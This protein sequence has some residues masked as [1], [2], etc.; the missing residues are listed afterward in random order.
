VHALAG[1]HPVRVLLRG[2]SGRHG[3]ETNGE[4]DSDRALEA[5]LEDFFDRRS[6]LDRTLDLLAITHPHIDHVHGA[7][8]VR[9]SFKVE[10]VVTNGFL[11]NAKGNY[12]S[13]G[14]QQENLE[15]WARAHA[16]LETIQTTAVP[17]GG[18]TSAVIDPLRC[19]DE[20]PRI[21]VLW[22]HQKEQP[23]DWNEE[24]FDDANNHS[25][26]VRI[27]FGAASF[28]VT[29]DLELDAVPE[30]VSKHEGSEALDVD[31]WQV[32]HHGSAN[33]T[34]KAILDAVTPEIALLG[35]G[36]P[37]R[38]QSKFTAFA[39]GHPRAGVIS[40]LLDRLSRRRM[41]AEVPVASGVRN[42]KPLDLRE[43]IYATG[44]DGSVVVTA[45]NE[46]K[47]RVRTN[48]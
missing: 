43:A 24:T 16:E 38:D 31:V 13:G 45:D 47:Y 36:D 44:W 12:H 5:Y 39:H 10:H 27:D 37:E 32:S 41:A 18:T 33:G 25:V 2:H 34:G 1:D 28:L 30:V 19:A 22:G 20:D 9:S 21:R 15:E 4:F 46:G 48:Q 35:T 8:L 26:V 6:D 11:K 17:K 14:R 23:G 3:G 7:E 40:Q 29:G 42:F